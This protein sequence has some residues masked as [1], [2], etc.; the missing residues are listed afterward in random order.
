M[1]KTTFAGLTRLDPSENIS[2]DGAS[3][4]S[5]NPRILDRLTRI[6]AVTHRHD[7]HAKLGDPDFTPSA[8]VV[9]SGGAIGSDETLYVGYT[10]TDGDGGETQLSPSVVVSTQPAYDAPET[11]P[12]GSADYSGGSLL[13]KTY[14]YAVTL[15]DGMG[16]ETTPTP[17]TQIEREPGFGSGQVRLG[18]LTADFEINEAVAWRL[19]R[20]D[21]G[22]EFQFLAQGSDDAYTDTGAIGPQC[23]V[24]PPSDGD[25]STNDTTSLIVRLPSALPSAAAMRLY[26]SDD[27]IFSDPSF[28]AEYPPAQANNDIV[29]RSIE[30]LDGRPPDV[31]TC[32]PGAYL[33]DPNTEIDWTHWGSAFLGSGGGVGGTGTSGTVRIVAAQNSGS[34]NDPDG[35][36]FVSSGG[37]RVG[38]HGASGS[39]VVT[40]TA[41]PGATGPQGPPGASGTPGSAGAPGASGAAGYGSANIMLKEQDGSP[42]IQ[43]I[44]HIEIGPGSGGVGAKVVDLGGGSGRVEIGATPPA[45]PPRQAQPAVGV[46]VFHS[47]NF[48]FTQSFD[49]GAYQVV[50]WESGEVEFDT[51]G[52]FLD[53]PDDTLNPSGFFDWPNRSRLT[54]PEGMGGM[55]LPQASVG[56]AHNENGPRKLQIRKG[57]FGGE[58]GV[59]FGGGVDVGIIECVPYTGGGSA[60]PDVVKAGSPVFLDAGE[61]V[62]LQVYQDSGVELTQATERDPDDIT[63]PENPIPDSDSG[64][65]NWFS[66]IRIG[67]GPDLI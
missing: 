38:V 45:T 51:D 10:L 25:N 7:A 59:A 34:V 58:A 41:L 14:Y 61:W 17:W 23:D 57:H 13:A 15:V 20:S 44:Q 48:A 60:P 6:G 19:Y 37:A 31:S 5:E 32:L 67:V 66:L 3:F 33:I 53:E 62:G 8:T 46:K 64:T 30:F 1:E 40:I 16:G 28:V 22:G 63:D 18:G 27:G 43:P 35:I 52:F 11:P 50:R 4:Q 54:V 9:A 2:A 24:H 49:W 47:F 55:Y 29:F 56:F 42:A 36:M 39:A 12:V 65:E 21:D 26:V